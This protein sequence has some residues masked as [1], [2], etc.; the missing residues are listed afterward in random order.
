MNNLNKPIDKDESSSSLRMRAGSENKPKSK[1]LINASPSLFD[2]KKAEDDDLGFDPKDPKGSF[3]STLGTD[4]FD[5]ILSHAFKNKALSKKGSSLQDTQEFIDDSKTDSNANLDS[6]GGLLVEL[7]NRS[8]DFSIDK[9]QENI[10][11]N[12]NANNLNG[13]RR[14]AAKLNAD[15]LG[16]YPPTASHLKLKNDALLHS[17]L[18]ETQNSEEQACENKPAE[19]VD[20]SKE[21][22]TNDET[23]L[24]S[25]NELKPS[26]GKALSKNVISGID[27]NELRIREAAILN[28]ILDQKKKLLHQNEQKET[29][30][31]SCQSNYS[32]SSD[33]SDYPEATSTKVHHSV[34]IQNKNYKLRSLKFENDNK[35]LI[36]ENY[37]LQGLICSIEDCHTKE[38]MYLERFYK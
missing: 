23:K 5:D 10:I 4:I 31:G 12:K 9:S 21:V 3:A 37:R 27:L 34:E 29:K 35:R 20:K 8:K 30:E 22:P 36:I 11:A 32:D 7:F 25:K 13:R 16:L 28:K 38:I 19:E 1:M 17:Q 18:D 24:E 33:D 15:W 26:T 14:I 6:K 2:L